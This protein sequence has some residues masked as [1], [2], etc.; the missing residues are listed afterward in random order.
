MIPGGTGFKDFSKR[1]A[2]SMDHEGGEE[3]VFS[4]EESL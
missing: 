2:K 4:F 1:I 3:L